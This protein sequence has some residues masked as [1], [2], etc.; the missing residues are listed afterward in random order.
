[1]VLLGLLGLLFGACKDQAYE[2][3]PYHQD[4]THQNKEAT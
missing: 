1:L 4:Q 2:G 3:L